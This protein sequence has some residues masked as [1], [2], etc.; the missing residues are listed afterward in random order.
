M[1]EI[2]ISI[3]ISLESTGEKQTL[4]MI[5]SDSDIRSDTLPSGPPFSLT[6][7]LMPAI[8]DDDEDGLLSKTTK[9][10][11]LCYA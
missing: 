8:S 7:Q 4:S 10:P 11:N 6:L 5:P 1:A 2:R 3:R 9:T